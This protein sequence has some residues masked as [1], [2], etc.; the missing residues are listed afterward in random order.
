[1][2]CLKKPDTLPP[3]VS[4]SLEKSEISTH[5]ETVENLNRYMIYQEINGL[6]YQWTE[7]EKDFPILKNSKSYST[8]G[9]RFLEY[10]ESIKRIKTIDE[11]DFLDLIKRIQCLK[12]NFSE[13]TH[14]ILNNHLLKQK[15]SELVENQALEL[16]DSYTEQPKTIPPRS[17]IFEPI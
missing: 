1:M 15:K 9:K 4:D 11:T 8:L 13:A 6:I 7:M 12:N 3:V 16:C 2:F 17:S 5:I 14:I 10:E